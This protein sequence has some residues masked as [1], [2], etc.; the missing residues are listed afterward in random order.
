MMRSKQK[1]IYKRELMDKWLQLMHKILYKVEG[2]EVR[3]GFMRTFDT[4]EIELKI[5]TD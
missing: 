4:N 5:S 2:K 1:L 3:F